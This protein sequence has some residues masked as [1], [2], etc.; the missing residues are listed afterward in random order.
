M[1]DVLHRTVADEW[2]WA[3]A[4]LDVV[5]GPTAVVMG[6]E[7]EILAER[8][9]L[10]DSPPI[11][12]AAGEVAI[13]GDVPAA[14]IGANA[15]PDAVPLPDSTVATVIASHAWESP[16]GIERVVKDANRLVE[17][18][19]AIVLAELDLPRLGRSSP[20]QYASALLPLALPDVAAGLRARS[21]L[22]SHLELELVRKGTAH[23]VAERFDLTRGLF[24][25]RAEHAA[26]VAAGLWRGTA[27]CSSG[28]LERLGEVVLESGGQG[29]VTDREPW[30][31]V[32]G[33]AA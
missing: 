2:N 12:A 22:H 19:G 25:D 17:R 1:A 15:T 9:L 13:L 3:L 4:S 14:M 8:L 32:R 20:L 23:V 6:A 18:G 27:A 21:A 16:A 7:A 10:A 24:D 11:V 33:I 26:A 31:L 28:E 29:P 30:V 5:W